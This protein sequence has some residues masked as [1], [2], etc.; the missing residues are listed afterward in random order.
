[1]D[2]AF[3]KAFD[4]LKAKVKELDKAEYIGDLLPCSCGNK[5]KIQRAI[6]VE[7]KN[8]VS[9]RCPCGNRSGWR[10]NVRDAAVSWNAIQTNHNMC[11]G[12]QKQKEDENKMD[13][14]ALKDSGERREFDTGAV[15]D[16]AEG[17]GN[18]V[19]FPP[20]ALLR[21]G[22]HYERGA[23]KYGGYNYLKGI[24]TQSFLDSA[25]RHLL[26]YLAGMDDEDHLAAAAF[27]ILGAMEMETKSADLQNIPNRKSKDCF[28]YLDNTK[29]GRSHES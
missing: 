5:P 19:Y 7:G 29:E 16:M 10:D 17:K 14:K 13:T 1:M 18:P 4:E 15:R 21:L 27:N 25:M 6:N 22:Q 8:M 23:K 12:L 20:M 28:N 9:L 3:K 11:A 26:K 2:T 24:P